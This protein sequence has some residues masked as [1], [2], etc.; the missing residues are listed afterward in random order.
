MTKKKA[1]KKPLDMTS[2]EAMEFLFSKPIVKE[3]K[4]VANPDKSAQATEKKDVVDGDSLPYTN[5]NK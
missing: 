2:D 1:Q 4:K 3:L 5:G